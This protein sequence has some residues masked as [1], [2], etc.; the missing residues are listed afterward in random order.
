MTLLRLWLVKKTGRFCHEA[1]KVALIG[2]Y[3]ESSYICYTAGMRLRVATQRD[4][5]IAL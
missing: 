4:F 3:L 1:H 5:G 2:R